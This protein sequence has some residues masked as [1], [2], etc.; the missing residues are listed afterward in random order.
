MPDNNNPFSRRLGICHMTFGNHP[1]QDDLGNF[2][3]GTFLF[4]FNF[5]E[6]LNQANNHWNNPDISA[7][8]ITETSDDIKSCVSGHTSDPNKNNIKCTLQGMPIFLK[9][10]ELHTTLKQIMSDNNFKNKESH[11]WTPCHN[12]CQPGDCNCFPLRQLAAWICLPQLCQL[13]LQEVCDSHTTAINCNAV[14]DEASTINKF[15]KLCE[16]F[17]K[18]ELTSF[19]IDTSPVPKLSQKEVWCKCDKHDINTPDVRNKN[20]E[21]S[22]NIATTT[23]N[24]N[25][26]I[27]C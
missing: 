12:Q 5:K 7:V 18:N 27:R 21:A 1:M 23:K 2:F 13:Q 24:F 8:V 16:L 9:I 14:F 6:L 10:S 17:A 3:S 22:I 20:F 25:A 19:T 26:A 15:K 11:A 4:N